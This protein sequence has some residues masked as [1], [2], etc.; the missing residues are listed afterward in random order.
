MDVLSLV[1]SSR[2]DDERLVYAEFTA[3]I[4][5]VCFYIRIHSDSHDNGL[6]AAFGEM[7]KSFCKLGFGTG[8][9]HHSCRFRIDFGE[10]LHMCIGFVMET[11]NKH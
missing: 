4:I 3:E 5:G 10:T 11:G 1:L 7:E 6:S 8:I 9:E 2:I